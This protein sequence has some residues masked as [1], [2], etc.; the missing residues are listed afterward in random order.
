MG[1]RHRWIEVL[2]QHSQVPVGSEVVVIRRVA[3]QL[4]YL[5]CVFQ[6]VHN[7]MLGK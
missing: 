6:N 5:Q 2:T 3:I 7:R 1:K 4:V